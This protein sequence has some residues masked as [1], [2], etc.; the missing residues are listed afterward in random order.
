MECSHLAASVDVSP[1]FIKRLTTE[2]KS[3]WTCSACRTNRSPWICLKCGIINCGRYINAHAKVHSEG[4]E[5]HY[6]CMDSSLM[7]FCY[8]CDEFVINDTKTGDI[9][10]IRDTLESADECSKGKK[11]RKISIDD[12][13]TTK[14]AKSDENSFINGKMLSK[15]TPGLRNLG[16]TCFMNAVL[17]SLSNLKHFSCYFKEI[18]AIELTEKNDEVAAKKYYTRSYKSDDLSLVEELRK[19]LCALW[20]GSTAAISPDELFAVVWKVVPRF[21]G[22]QQHDA[23]EFM[24]YLLDRVHT[25][26][27]QSNKF[28]NGKDTIVTSIFGGH[29]QSDVTCLNCKQLSKKQELYL[30]LSL[31]IPVRHHGHKSKISRP[32]YLTDGLQRFVDV[33]ELGDTEWYMCPGCSKKQPSTKK[34]W[35]TS[36]S[37]VLCLHLKR[38]RYSQFGRSKVDTYVKFPLQDLNMNQFLL[39][40]SQRQKENR[41]NSKRNIYDLAAVVVHHGSGLTSGHYTT[42]AWHEGLWYH[43]NDSSVSVVSEEAVARCKA[44]ILFYTRRHPDTTVI[45]RIKGKLAV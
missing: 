43:F 2:N 4:S 20:Q 44:Y 37:N 36:L 41:P 33:E 39:K 19:I 3:T 7:A 10:L 30:D 1:A 15:H 27:L 14:K 13:D 25:E 40:Q 29:L 32:C 8:K 18:P 22:Y 38:F 6:V 35:L 16:N 21:R 26:L 17:Q 5:G 23:H 24:H 31:D 28:S 9:Q 45:E 42:Y 34:Y 11:K 12:V